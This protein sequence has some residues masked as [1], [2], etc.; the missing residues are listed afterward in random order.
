MFSLNFHESLDM[1]TDLVLVQVLVETSGKLSS[2]AEHSTRTSGWRETD[3]RQS[4]RIPNAEFRTNPRALGYAS[5]NFIGEADVAIVC[6]SQLFQFIRTLKNYHV[7]RRDIVF[8]AVCIY[9]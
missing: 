2:T 7:S 1:A 9:S 6:I 4:L 5:R 3:K 8:V